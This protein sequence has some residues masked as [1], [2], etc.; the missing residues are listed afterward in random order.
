MY[1]RVQRCDVGFRLIRYDAHVYFKVAHNCVLMYFC[2]E[3]CSHVGT[4]SGRLCV[5]VCAAMRAGA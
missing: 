4:T 5:G 1:F 3:F 2:V